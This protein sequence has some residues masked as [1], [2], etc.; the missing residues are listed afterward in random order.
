MKIFLNARLVCKDR[1]IQRGFLTEKDGIITSLG[2]MSEAPAIQ[3]EI[4]DCRGL[5]LSPGFI[6]LHTHGAGGYDFM[7]GS[8]RDVIGAARTQM[9][10]GTTALMPTTLT[11]DDEDLY[12]AIDAYH[13]ALEVKENMPHLLGL[14]LEGPYFA[15]EHKGAQDERY[16][17]HPHPEHYLKIL[18][19]ARGHIKRWSFAPELPGALEMADRL[20][21]SGI[22]LSAA[23]TSATFEQ[24]Q[25][26]FEHGITHLTHFYSAMSSIVRIN[27]M[28]TL[29]VVESG[30][31][32][33]GLTLEIISDGIHLPP[34]LL[35][36]ILRCKDHN[37]IC[38]CTDSMRGA[39]M[40]DGPSILG[41]KKDGQK[42]IVEDGIALMPDRSCFAGSVAT[43]DRLVRVMVYQAGLSVWE[44]VKM[45]SLNP[46]RFVNMDSKIGSLEVGKQADLVLFDNDI[47]IKSV[48]VSGIKTI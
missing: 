34:N 5:Y 14:H 7:D 24:M 1:I 13:Q 36:M 40:P 25:Q 23:H 31:L 11:S 29:G 6:D 18:A 37:A 2:D 27:G 48:Y 47:S 3:E 16:L 12:A 45:M 15:S 8:V 22:L 46:A 17:M 28:R 43:T 38:L 35:R 4:V 20:A 10:H 33:D 21:D 42:V 39:G 44:A 26:A 19:Y 9:A 32:L 30:Y 41:S